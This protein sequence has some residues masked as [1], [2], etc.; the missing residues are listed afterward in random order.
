[1]IYPSASP[2]PFLA[3]T[4][5][6]AIDTE[7]RDLGL[8]QGLGSGWFNCNGEVLGISLA[9]KQSGVLKKYYFPIAHVS[10]NL[11]RGKVVEFFKN[12]FATHEGTIIF[13]NAV[14]DLGW[15]GT[16][17]ITPNKQMKIRDTGYAAA[18]LDENR[19]S[20]RLDDLGKEELGVGKD[21]TLLERA[22]K[23]LGCRSM[24]QL[25]GRLQELPASHVAPYAAQDAEVTLLLYEKFV[26]E[27]KRQALLPLFDLECRQIPLLIAMRK[28]GV[29][30]D[31]DRVRELISDFKYREAK[32]Q[33][34][35]DEM[36]GEPFPNTRTAKQIEII[37]RV[38]GA[39]HFKKSAV[40]N[41][42]TGKKHIRNLKHPFLEKITELN[43]IRKLRRDFLE[44]FLKFEV[45][46][47]LHPE[48]HPLKTN[49]E[50]GS[51]LMSTKT[52][53]YSSSCIA[54]GTMI[55]MPAGDKPIEDVQV[56]DLVYCFSEEGKLE[57][58]PVT[59]TRCM[60]VKE[61]VQ[62]DWKGT[63]NKHTGTL[64]CTPDHKLKTFKRGWVAAEDLQFNE[65]IYHLHRM[66]SGDRYR[67]FAPNIA[68]L[69]EESVL[70]TNYFNAESKMHIHHKDFNKRNNSVDNLVVLTSQEHAS[71]HLKKRHA[72]GKVSFEHLKHRKVIPKYGADNPLWSKITKE[73]LL[74]II[75]D[76]KGHVNNLPIDYY[77][78]T[79]HCEAEG[80]NWRAECGKYNYNFKKY[81]FSYEDIDRAMQ[82]H[83]G[84]V[85]LAAKELGITYGVLMSTFKLLDYSYNHRIKGIIPAGKHKVYDLTVADNE[86]FIANELCV[87]NCPNI[88]NIPADGELGHLIRTCFIPE[89]GCDWFCADY[90]QQEYRWAAHIAI[91]NKCEG[92]ETVKKMY[93]ENPDLDFHNLGSMLLFGNIDHDNRKKVKTLGFGILYGQGL[94]GFADALGCTK[95]EAGTLLEQYKQKVPFVTAAMN[96][97]KRQAEGRGYVTTYLKR[98]RRY[99]FFETSEREDTTIVKGRSAAIAK[100]LDENDPW[101]NKQ[102][103]R[104]KTYTAINSMCQGSSADQTKMAA[105]Y[106]FEKYGIVPHIM[107]HDEFDLSIPKGDELTAKRVIHVMENVIKLHIPVKAEGDV[108]PNWGEA[109][110]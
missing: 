56:G 48:F 82:K 22:M 108:G 109:K 86:N 110:G 75:K 39:E 94:Q 107:V 83:D 57:V 6:L 13:H 11:D 91:E 61:C 32:V 73:E 76:C 102:L 84:K 4:S 38:V 63:G 100:V 68:G 42:L 95:E 79:K 46:G 90:G 55:S 14:Y 37:V 96:M 80:I 7:T 60:G 1:M 25:M 26:P 24:G 50:G 16:L 106:L 9:Y 29:R 99:D 21:Y 72:E 19:F 3:P 43:S 44:N 17:G 33:Q 12:L 101:H 23:R 45:D 81:T 30:I 66:D 35:L 53:R 74:Q 54:E 62:L 58:K 85:T 88:Q 8:Q 64:I 71:L 69:T 70:K 2:F 67:L 28:Q 78:F 20:Y 98:R 27:L 51:S 93:E 40:G 105:V 92:W 47:R 59:A 18:L 97:A 41:Y 103:R 15:L 77:T 104:Y 5:V 49:A 34:E 36:A 10:G 65:R 87:H 89:D 52:G 31:L